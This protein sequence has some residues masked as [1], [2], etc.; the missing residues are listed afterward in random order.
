[1][2]GVGNLLGYT[3]GKGVSLACTLPAG[4]IVAGPPCQQDY[5][6]IPTQRIRDPYA[7]LSRALKEHEQLLGIQQGGYALL[8]K[9][10][11]GDY[12]KMIL[13]FQYTRGM[14]VSPSFFAVQY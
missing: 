7:F 14:A 6:I 1:M 9:N 4:E 2:E 12:N 11:C 10:G 13:A 8:W 5:S 3:R